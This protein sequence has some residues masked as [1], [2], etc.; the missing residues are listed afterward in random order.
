M[1]III[2]S[3]F[4]QES[5]IDTGTLI[6]PENIL[7]INN[8]SI[9]WDEIVEILFVNPIS[10]NEIYYTGAYYRGEGIFWINSNGNKAEILKTYIRYGPMVKWH[11]NNI[12]EIYIPIGSPFRHSYFYDFRDDTLSPPVNFPIYY[13]IEND[14]IIAVRDGGLDL[15]DLKNIVIRKKYDFEENISALYLLVFSDYELVIEN[16][17]LYFKFKIHTRDMDIE[18]EYIFDYN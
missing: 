11:G 14:Y 17:R 16:K 12:V 2:S 5:E 4:S 18:Q 15:Y 1:F 3:I 7:I 8:N 13:D 10:G 6:G 9:E